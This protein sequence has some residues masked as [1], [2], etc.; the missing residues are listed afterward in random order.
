MIFSNTNIINVHMSINIKTILLFLLR[1][2]HVCYIKIHYFLLSYEWLCLT[3]IVN[4]MFICQFHLFS[5]IYL[6]KTKNKSIILIIATSSMYKS[7]DSN[8]I[9]RLFLQKFQ[10][11]LTFC[12]FNT[13]WYLFFLKCLMLEKKNHSEN[14]SN[15]K[16][17]IWLSIVLRVFS[18]QS[19]EI[20]YMRS[21]NCN[22]S[23]WPDVTYIVRGDIL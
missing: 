15:N 23:A 8:I 18:P 1:E 22:C 12:S 7:L 5:S 16:H 19:Q 6:Q 21:D 3:V 20:F 13:K 10:D 2:L 14:I 9:G 4:P 11:L 17:Q